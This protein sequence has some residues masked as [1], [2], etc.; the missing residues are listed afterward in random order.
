MERF[1]RSSVQNSTVFRMSVPLTNQ[2]GV[3]TSCSVLNESGQG[4]DQLAESDKG[5]Y[6]SHAFPTMC[7]KALNSRLW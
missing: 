1:A 5:L 6:N 3:I 2:G 4:L 7:D